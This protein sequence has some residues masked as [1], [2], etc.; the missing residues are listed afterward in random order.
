[1]PDAKG[2]TSPVSFSKT[3][4]DEL[5][6][7]GHK[8]ARTLKEQQGISNIC[9]AQSW[10]EGGLEP[11]VV[12]SSVEKAMTALEKELRDG[13]IGGIQDRREL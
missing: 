9:H 12:P 8:T 7:H 10:S 3:I 4:E 1:M 5:K 11:A 6:A 2:Q 13:F